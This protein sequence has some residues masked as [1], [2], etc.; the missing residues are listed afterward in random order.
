MHLLLSTLQI[1]EEQATGFGMSVCMG[2]IWA[3]S[4]RTCEKFDNGI[5]TKSVDQIQVLLNQTKTTEPLRDLR[6]S[7]KTPRRL[8]V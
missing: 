5:L 8:T 7:T 1:C 6:L 2:S 4:R 3:P